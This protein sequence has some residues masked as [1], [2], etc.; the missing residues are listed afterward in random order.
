MNP[1][2]PSRSRDLTNSARAKMR[3]LKHA[4]PPLAHATIPWHARCAH[5]RRSFARSFPHEPSARSPPRMAWI[6]RSLATQCWKLCPS[7]PLETI[8]TSPRKLKAAMRRSQNLERSR[9]PWR[10]FVLSSPQL[11]PDAT[12]STRRRSI[13]S[14]TQATWPRIQALRSLEARR[15]KFHSPSNRADANLDQDQMVAARFPTPNSRRW[16]C[17]SIQNKKPP[18]RPN[19]IASSWPQQLPVADVVPLDY[20]AGCLVSTTPTQ[21]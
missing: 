18:G 6:M 14:S 4:A 16:P 11:H 12:R 9:Q 1:S 20:P 7:R 5:I 3:S 15:V 2:A 13:Q 21:R 17:P 19:D 8:P 10:T